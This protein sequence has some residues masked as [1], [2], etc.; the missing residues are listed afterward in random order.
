MCV[1]RKQ[2]TSN[3]PKNNNF[4]PPQTHTCVCVSGGKKYSFFGK[5]GVLCFLVTSVL[6]Y[7]LL[8]YYRRIVSHSFVASDKGKIRQRKKAENKILKLIYK[9]M[10]T[11]PLP[12]GYLSGIS[13]SGIIFCKYHRKLLQF[14]FSLNFFLSETSPPCSGFKFARNE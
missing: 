2:S 14:S 6:R 9:W 8:P 10:L 12:Y 13:N 3:F 11:S 1:T 7:A 4:L 5:L